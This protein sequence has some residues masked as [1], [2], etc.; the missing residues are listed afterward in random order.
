MVILFECVNIVLGAHVIHIHNVKYLGQP[1]LEDCDQL[2]HI[3]II[4][5][6]SHATE[7]ACFG[8]PSRV[9]GL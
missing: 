3:G 5:K 9:L 8:G 6:D 1:L 2:K 4:L 7:V